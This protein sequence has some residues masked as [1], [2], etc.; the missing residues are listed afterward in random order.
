MIKK[1]AKRSVCAACALSVLALASGAAADEIG[2]ASSVENQVSGT[3]GTR[4]AALNTGDSV[5]HNEQISSGAGGSA[6]LMFLDETIFNIG[7]N[8]DVVLDEFVYNPNAGTGQI[9]LNVSRGTFRFITGSARPESYTIR[10]PTA[11]IG[12]RGTIFKGIV[13]ALRTLVTLLQGKLY[14]CPVRPNDSVQGQGVDQNRVNEDDCVLVE[15]P[16]QYQIGQNVEG[17]GD[18][19][20]PGGT[21]PNDAEDGESGVLDPHHPYNPGPVCRQCITKGP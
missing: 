18:N 19:P 10:T 6:Q 13:D 4:S 14:I 7:P 8:S 12:V 20:P 1:F 9:I 17:G 15:E 3:L 2:V 16:G 11:T 21:D 5:F